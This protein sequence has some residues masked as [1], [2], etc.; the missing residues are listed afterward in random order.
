M[1]DAIPGVRGGEYA[2]KEADGEMTEKRTPMAS[3]IGY[4]RSKYGEG[5]LVDSSDNC[6]SG[7]SD[8]ESGYDW[9]SDVAP[10]RRVA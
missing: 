8:M 10:L 2:D 5:L 1:L 6:L 4:M 7:E 9:F 3:I